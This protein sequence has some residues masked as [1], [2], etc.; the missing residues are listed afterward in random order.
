MGTSLGEQSVRRVPRRAATGARLTW[1]YGQCGHRSCQHSP[2]AAIQPR[3][4]PKN[5]K[6]TRCDGRA[7]Q[8]AGGGCNKKKP[9]QNFPIMSA[10]ELLLR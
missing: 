5:Q 4:L 9:T 1:L 8:S 3:R 7:A 2:T 10:A 6:P